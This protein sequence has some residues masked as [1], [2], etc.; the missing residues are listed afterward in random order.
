[1]SSK[2][3]KDFLDLPESNNNPD[4]Y[5]L[6]DLPK[7]MSNFN[8]AFIERRPQDTFAERSKDDNNSINHLE[9]D[10]FSDDDIPSPTTETTLLKFQ[11]AM[12][13]WGMRNDSSPLEIDDLEIPA[14]R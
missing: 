1:M 6:L 13:S 11:N 4:D 14:G 9:V 7:N 2:R 10:H 3:I 12:F 8:D 5:E